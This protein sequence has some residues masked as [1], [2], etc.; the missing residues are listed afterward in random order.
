[1]RRLRK[2]RKSSCFSSSLSF[3]FPCS[4]VEK[5]EKTKKEKS[6]SLSRFISTQSPRTYTSLLTFSPPSPISL[7]FERHPNS[8][9]K[10][11]KR[12]TRVWKKISKKERKREPRC[13]R[14]VHPLVSLPSLSPSP[15]LLLFPLSKPFPPFPCRRKGKERR[16][17][18]EKYFHL[19]A[20]RRT[21]QL[22]SS[23]AISLRERSLLLTLPPPSSSSTPPP[24][25]ARHTPPPIPG[26]P[27]AVFLRFLRPVQ[28]L[29]FSPFLPPS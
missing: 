27:P 13:V 14:T 6:L 20:K 11:E 7:Y 25:P 22:S 17:A 23:L 2:K 29:L 10:R 15:F 9:T 3:Q 12:P 28:V 18:I 26:P 24:Y 19:S 4:I 5:E 16:D 8:A 1:M 21:L